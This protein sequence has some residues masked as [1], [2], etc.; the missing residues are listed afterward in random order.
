MPK[1]F[2]WSSRPPACLNVAGMY[3]GWVTVGLKR[4]CLSITFVLLELRVTKVLSSE[5]SVLS[6]NMPTQN[7]LDSKVI[8]HNLLG[9]FLCSGL[10]RSFLLSSSP[11]EHVLHAVV[12][13]IAGVLK[14]GPLRLGARHFCFPRL[15]PRVR[16]VNREFVLHRFLA[17]AS[18]AFGQFEIPACSL[19]GNFV[20][21]VRGFYNESVPF[22]VSAR[23]AQP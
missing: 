7:S 20:V 6:G 2:S 10:G 23:I 18:Q 22:P 3:R 5:L 11:C 4:K 19:E 8:T 21:K 13:F 14:D 1:Q 17:G 15:G 12:P 16:V 9:F